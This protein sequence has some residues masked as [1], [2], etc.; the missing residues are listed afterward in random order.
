MIAAGSMVKY[1]KR[2]TG[3]KL[4]RLIFDKYNIS[5]TALP[6]DID[7]AKGINLWNPI[8]Y[9]KFTYTESTILR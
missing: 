5:D 8:A 4:P 7:I 2:I 9:E 1:L 6:I 3:K